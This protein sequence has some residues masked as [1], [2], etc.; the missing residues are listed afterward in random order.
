MSNTVVHIL[1]L[2]LSAVTLI[3]SVLYLVVAANMLKGAQDPF[4]KQLLISALFYI[5]VSLFAL[6]VI[7]RSAESLLGTVNEF[8]NAHEFFTLLSLVVFLYAL[9][10]RFETNAERMRLHHVESKKAKSR[11]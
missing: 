9:S 1:A 10:Q 4:K 6:S 3:F 2:I 8:L 5:A 11:R 7:M